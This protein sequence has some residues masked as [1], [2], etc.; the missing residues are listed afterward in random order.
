M[1]KK[2]KYSNISHKIPQKLNDLVSSSSNTYNLYSEFDVFST[3]HHSIGLL[4]QPTL[5]NTSI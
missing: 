4:L 3:V 2:Y 5:M 1:H